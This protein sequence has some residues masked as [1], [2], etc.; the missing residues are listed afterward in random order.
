MEQNGKSNVAI[1][2]AQY[3]HLP[4]PLHKM[5]AEILV[6]RKEWAVKED[7]VTDLKRKDS[8]GKLS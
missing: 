5:T 4:S 6:A 8:S 7:G 3:A 2:P 1:T